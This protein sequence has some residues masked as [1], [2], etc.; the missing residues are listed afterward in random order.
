MLRARNQNVRKY[1]NCMFLIFFPVGFHGSLRSLKQTRLLV[2]LGSKVMMIMVL[3][4]DVG[5]EDDDDKTAE[6]PSGS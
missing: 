1:I 5:D 3:L 6:I 4:E 2:P